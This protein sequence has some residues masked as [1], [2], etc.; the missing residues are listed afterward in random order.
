MTLVVAEKVLEKDKSSKRIVF[1][2]DSRVSFG[3]TSVNY[4]AKIFSVPLEIL[5]YNRNYSKSYTQYIGVA[6]CGSIFTGYTVKDMIGDMFKK[7]QYESSIENLDFEY[8]MDLVLEKYQYIL[9]N[10]LERLSKDYL[11]QIIVGGFCYN[12]KKIRV[13]YFSEKEVDKEE[14]EEGILKEYQYN[15]E[16]ILLENERFFM[17]SAKAKKHAESYVKNHNKEAFFGLEDT[18]NKNID[19]TVGGEIQYGDFVVGD[20]GNYDFR[21]VGVSKK[22][23][24]EYVFRGIRISKS[25]PS[26]NSN[27]LFIPF[28]YLDM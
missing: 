9:S 5:S 12:Q 25:Y 22:M 28:P 10:T 17:G 20:Q 13:F 11:S 14:N 2:S 7:V 6:I 27:G 26:I 18:I 4:G 3:G 8:L 21:L 19:S 23:T 16:E 24:D 15:K 1:C